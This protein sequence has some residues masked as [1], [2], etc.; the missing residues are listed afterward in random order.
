MY[1]ITAS[2]IIHAPIQKVWDYMLDIENW[3]PKSNPEHVSLEYLGGRHE[4]SLGARIKIREYI[5]GVPCEAVGEITEFTVLE[6]ASWVAEAEYSYFGFKVKVKEGVR[7]LFAN[8]E[9]GVELSAYVWAEF[10]NTLFG[11]FVE[12]Y[13]LNVLKGA[14]KDYEHTMRELEYIKREVE[15]EV[16]RNN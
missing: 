12:W 3:W 13:F 9:E 15:K 2:I 7:W 5:A 11:K 1:N 8:K 10:P 6:K 4:L 14:K 16:E